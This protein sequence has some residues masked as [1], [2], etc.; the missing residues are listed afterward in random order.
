MCISM[1]S[2][3]PAGIGPVG[4]AWGLAVKVE[5]AEPELL[6]A[7]GAHPPGTLDRYQ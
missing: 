5:S 6:H 2:C 4:E 3:L 1:P 7:F